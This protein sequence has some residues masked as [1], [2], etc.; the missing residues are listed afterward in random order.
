MNHVTVS[1]RAFIF[2]MLMRL[3]ALVL[4][5]ANAVEAYRLRSVS[6][7]ALGKRVQRLH[8]VLRREQAAVDGIH[9]ALL[10][11]ADG[12][13]YRHLRTA[14]HRHCD[15]VDSLKWALA[16]TEEEFLNGCELVEAA[17]ARIE[18]AHTET[19][20]RHLRTIAA[21]REVLARID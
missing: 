10:N 7:I 17:K 19:V 15:A 20:Q 11:A 6:A 4:P 5:Y 18:E 21:C 12:L 8:V 14:L 16:A 1:V 2:T 9:T 3:E 13:E